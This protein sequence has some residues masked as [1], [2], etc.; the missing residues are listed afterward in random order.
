MVRRASHYTQFVGI[1]VA[2][3]TIE[4][5]ERVAPSARGERSE[6]VRRAIEAAL[7]RAEAAEVDR[8]DERD[9]VLA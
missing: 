7:D 2:D 6:F 5:L 4:R 8:E 1:T 3:R 9:G